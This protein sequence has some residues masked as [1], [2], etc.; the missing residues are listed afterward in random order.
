MTFVS[1]TL[2]PPAFL[3]Y[4]S[5]ENHGLSQLFVSNRQSRS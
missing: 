4:L 1:F 5:P 3:F 2:F